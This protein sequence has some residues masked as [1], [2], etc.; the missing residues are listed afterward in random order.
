MEDTLWH[1]AACSENFFLIL[2][3]NNT[4]TDIKK[5]KIPIDKFDGLALARLGAF[6]FIIIARKDVQ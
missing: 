3:S 4:Y 6:H 1:A 2:T 5:Q